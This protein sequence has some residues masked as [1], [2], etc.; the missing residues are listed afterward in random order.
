MFWRAYSPWR[1]TTAKICTA[2]LLRLVQVSAMA[3]GMKE[4]G[5][6]L[7]FGQHL[8]GLASLH[9]MLIILTIC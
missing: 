7:W 6:S 9:P 4:S 2:I 1:G 8:A 3:T 5:L